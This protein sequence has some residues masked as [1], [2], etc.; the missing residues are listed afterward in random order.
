MKCDGKTEVYSRITGY[1]SPV[2][3]WNPGKKSEYKDRKEYKVEVGDG[4]C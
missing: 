4:N 1:Y 2:H 3:R